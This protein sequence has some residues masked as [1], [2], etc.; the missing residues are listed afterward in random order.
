MQVGYYS[1][2]VNNNVLC[3]IATSRG[4]EPLSTHESAAPYSHRKP[5]AGFGNDMDTFDVY[6][7]GD[8]DRL[9]V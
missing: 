1:V 4:R 8:L 9:Q 3:R 5:P 7:N 2:T 6:F